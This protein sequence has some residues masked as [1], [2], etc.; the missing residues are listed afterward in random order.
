MLD[1]NRTHN[2][3]VSKAGSTNPTETPISDYQQW[4]SRLKTY[5]N[6]VHD[7]PLAQHAEHVAALAAQTVVVV[8]EAW[9]DGSQSSASGP[10]P[11]V[12]SYAEINKQFEEEV[13]ALSSACPR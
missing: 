5:A 7:G 4:A 2:A 3:A 10:P 13:S 1:F 12:R 6:E 8:G 9:D 11:W